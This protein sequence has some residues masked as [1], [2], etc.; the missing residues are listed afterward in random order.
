M[1]EFVITILAAVIEMMVWLVYAMVL[2]VG[3]CA[4]MML[5]TGGRFGIGALRV[6]RRVLQRRATQR[7]LAIIAS[8]YLSARED[9]QRIS[10]TTRR[11]I[12]DLTEPRR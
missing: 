1:D 4:W 7:E 12:R 2:A 6:G 9:I 8:E 11:R 3:W 10:Q 5:V